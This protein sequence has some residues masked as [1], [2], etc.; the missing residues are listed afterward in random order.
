MYTL[1]MGAGSSQVTRNAFVK[2]NFLAFAVCLHPHTKSKTG[3]NFH[4]RQS[5]FKMHLKWPK[6]NYITAAFVGQ[7]A[8][9]ASCTSN[10]L[11]VYE[12]LLFAEKSEFAKV[13][14]WHCAV[15]VVPSLVRLVPHVVMHHARA[16]FCSHRCFSSNASFS[17]LVVHLKAKATSCF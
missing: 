17:S 10:G 9:L 1:F 12:A 7:R 16:V 14:I 13:L 8:E 15:H 11:T 3:R 2:D 5:F 4:S 6:K